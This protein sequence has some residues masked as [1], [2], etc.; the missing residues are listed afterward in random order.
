MGE[1]SQ[2]DMPMPLFSM[3]AKQKCTGTGFTKWTSRHGSDLFLHVASFMCRGV[4]V[5][6]KALS[7][8]AKAV[9]CFNK[10]KLSKGLQFGRAFQL[11]R[12]GGNFLLVG[13]CTSLRMEDKAS[14]CPMIE[15]HQ[16]LFGQGMLQSFG[17]DKGY[18][19]RANNNYL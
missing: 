8:H 14:V 5:P 2:H 4:M 15:E 3:L 11:G 1:T 9:S 13:S 7:F 18:Y 16:G 6:D 19:S 10:G 12:I 17:T